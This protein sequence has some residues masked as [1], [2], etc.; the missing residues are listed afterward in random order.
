MSKAIAQVLRFFIPQFAAF[1]IEKDGIAVR[2]DEIVAI[3]PA[4]TDD[5]QVDPSHSV[6]RLKNDADIDVPYSVTEIV[7][8]FDRH[9]NNIAV[10]GQP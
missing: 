7:K 2:L 9:W 3:L 10:I 5:G 6:L 8:A 4:K 1:R